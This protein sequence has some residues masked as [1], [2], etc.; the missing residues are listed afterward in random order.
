M[1]IFLEEEVHSAKALLKATF[2]KL[3]LAGGLPH[4]VKEAC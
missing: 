3:K 1:R 2:N 4:Y